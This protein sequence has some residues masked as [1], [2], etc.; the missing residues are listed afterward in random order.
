MVS[1]NNV[2]EGLLGNALRNEYRLLMKGGG[3]L[4]S[5]FPYPFIP[6][7]IL[8]LLAPTPLHCFDCKI[9]HN[10]A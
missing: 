4:T 1:F 9:L 8:Y 7:P 10:V 3:G 6:V 5:C 2:I